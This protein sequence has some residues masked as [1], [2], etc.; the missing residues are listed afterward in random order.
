[1]HLYKRTFATKELCCMINA[2]IKTLLRARSAVQL[3]TCGVRYVGVSL[4]V[5]VAHQLLQYMYFT[6]CRATLIHVLFFRSS[7]I[8][9]MLKRALDFLEGNAIR[10]FNF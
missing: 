4:L 9:N 6:Q 8:C 2:S 10:A 7:D 5:Y 1:M 3:F